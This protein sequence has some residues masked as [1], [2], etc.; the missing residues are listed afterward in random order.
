MAGGYYSYV[1]EAV[2]SLLVNTP[3]ARAALYQR[4]RV[5]MIHRLQSGQKPAAQ[6]EV[7]AHKAALEK[8]IRLIELATTYRGHIEKGVHALAENT[9]TLRAALYQR[10]S[11][12]LD[13]RLH[14]ANPPLAAAQ[15]AFHKTALDEAIR[16]VEEDNLRVSAPPDVSAIPRREAARADPRP[17]AAAKPAPPLAYRRLRL[18]AGILLI[19][20]IGLVIASMVLAGAQADLPMLKQAVDIAWPILLAV[21]LIYFGYVVVCRRRRVEEAG[22]R[23][24]CV[25]SLAVGLGRSD[26]QRQRQLRLYQEAVRDLDDG[27]LFWAAWLPDHSDDGRK[28]AAAELERRGHSVAELQSWS[29]PASDLTVPPTVDRAISTRG[30]ARLILLRRAALILFRVGSLVAFAILAAAIFDY[31]NIDPAL[32]ISGVAALIG[33]PLLLLAFALAFMVQDRARRILVLRPFGEKKMTSALKR[34]VRKS[35]GLRAYAFTLSDRNYKPSF[36]DSML[37]RIVS[38]GFETLGQI[39]VGAIFANSHRLGAIK[40]DKTFFRF[41]RALTQKFNL[42]YWSFIT[43]GQAFN[44]RTTD[45][46]WQLCVQLLMH[47]CDV[48]VVDLSLVKQGTAW[49]IKQLGKRT[50]R[51][52]CI[53]VV[54]D[55]RRSTLDAVMAEHFPRDAPQVHVYQKSGALSDKAAFDA[56]FKDIFERET[57]R[58]TTSK[59]GN[60]EHA[61]ARGR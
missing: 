28:F 47:S 12:Q 14:A 24:R 23:R 3:E 44:I 8:A 38:G 51:A 50:L 1:A 48:I 35:L 30:Y 20:L 27:A 36:V 43:S 52:K 37:F 41:A 19:V 54:S 4:M 58:G 56:A 39:A 15:I 45:P 40:N 11:M 2:G 60:A 49:E 13:Q 33:L 61:C 22:I 21:L 9:P 7:D 55:E 42:S 10:A 5:A 53:F 34:F 46:F 57:A 31:E 16:M 29:P 59:H 17:E 26:A 25:G 18:P 32:G 6:N